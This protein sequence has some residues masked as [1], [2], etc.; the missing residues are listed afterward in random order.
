MSAPGYGETDETTDS[1]DT[2]EWPKHV[3]HN[4]GRVGFAGSSY[5]ASTP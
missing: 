2:V 1:Y 4:N 5:P 3:P